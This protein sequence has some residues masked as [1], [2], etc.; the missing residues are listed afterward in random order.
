MCRPN[1]GRVL[2]VVFDQNQT[3]LGLV[4]L[5]LREHHDE[6]MQALQREGKNDE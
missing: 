1:K 3:P 5:R 4:R 6:L 2:C